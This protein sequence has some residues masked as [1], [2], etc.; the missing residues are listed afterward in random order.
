M[1]IHAGNP[2]N[3]MAKAYNTIH[4]KETTPIYSEIDVLEPKRC[5]ILCNE[6]VDLTSL[7]AI[8]KK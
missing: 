5:N 3:C 7:R 4:M 8:F 1:F 2:Y 6:L